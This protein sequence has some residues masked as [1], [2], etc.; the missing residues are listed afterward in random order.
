MTIS[1]PCT[2]CRETVVAQDEDD[3]VR[4]IQ[5]HARDHGG[6]HGTH[7]PSREHILAHLADRSGHPQADS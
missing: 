2:R 5:A 7:I 3:L 4:Q 6:A 1:M